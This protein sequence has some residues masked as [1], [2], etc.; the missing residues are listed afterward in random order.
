MS[1]TD[2]SDSSV[3]NPAHKPHEERELS[4]GEGHITNNRMELTAAINGL[5]AL[6]ETCEVESVTD[7]QHLEEGITQYL[8]RWKTNG[9]RTPNQEASTGLVA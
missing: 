3:R 9:W 5:K 4:G 2:R 6:R 7:P 1:Q 8:Y